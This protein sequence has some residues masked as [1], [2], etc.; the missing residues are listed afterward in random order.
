MFNISDEELEKRIQAPTKLYTDPAPQDQL[1]PTTNELFKAQYPAPFEVQN[2]NATYLPND[3]TR[4]TERSKKIPSVPHQNLTRSNPDNYDAYFF[5]EKE[6]PRTAKSNLKNEIEE[7]SVI[8]KAAYLYG[9]TAGRALMTSAYAWTGA[10][11]GFVQLWLAILFNVAIGIVL[12]IEGFVGSGTTAEAF[13]LAMGAFGIN[14]DFYI[15]AFL[16]YLLLIVV[17]YIQLFGV[18][19]QAKIMLLHPLN[20]KGAIWKYSSFLL[21]F[22]LYWIPVAN[23][24]PLVYLYIASI[25]LNPR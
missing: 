18:L 7:N 12:A 13:S 1:H 22:A 4:T 2:A 21:C 24:F 3:T 6:V 25:Q 14:W 10:I 16:C 9:K 5:G 19:I 15:V 23:L 11:Y 20:G 8:E 17:C